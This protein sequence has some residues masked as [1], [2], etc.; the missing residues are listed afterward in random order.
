MSDQLNSNID[1]E[2]APAAS[3]ASM[4]R[5]AKTAAVASLEQRL[6]GEDMPAP[7]AETIARAVVDPADARKRLDRLTPIRVPGG[8]VYA[9]E[10]TVW[11]T[12][13]VP[14]VV[15][16]REAPDRH[17]PAGIKLGSTEAARY[18][19]LRPP[20]NA[21]DGSARLEI[22]AR[23]KKHLIWSLERSAKFLL[24]HNNWTE[25]IGAQGVMQ[26]VT[27]AVVDVLFDNGEPTVTMLGSVDGSS[28]V[29]SSH[30]VL[31]VTPHDVLYRYAQDERAHRQFISTLLATLE[32][33]ATSVPADDVTKLRALEIPARIFVRF[34]PD[35]VT[36]ITFSKAVESF[37][38]LVHVETPQA[39]DPAASLDAKADSVLNELVSEG[40]IT[41][42]RKAYFEGMLTPE[43]ARAAKMPQYLDERALEI[44]AAI[45]SEKAANYRAV[46]QGILLL[47][48]GGVVQRGPKAE[49]AVE[50]A[51]RGYRSNM[52]RAEQKGA[53]ETLQNVYLHSDIWAKGLRPTGETPEE[54]RDAALAELT[55]GGPKTA[56][57]RLAAQA[58][59]WLAVQR[60][61]REARFFDTDKNLRDP[62]TPQRVLND[63]MRTPRGVHVLYRA[64]VDGRDKVPI[65][66]VDEKGT[67]VKGVSGK[68]LEANHAWVRTT[69][70]PPV[71]PS[72]SK[73]LAD[74]TNGGPSL[75]D[76][77][78]LTRLGNLRQAVDHLEDAHAQLRD[79]KDAS[80]KVLVDQDGIAADTVDDLLTRLDALRT[81]L[82][83]YRKTWKEKNAVQ[84]ED[85]AADDDTGEPITDLDN[86]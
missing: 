70:A 16:N 32:K 2:P 7:M 8:I 31:G 9:L 56:C 55:A 24:D 29:N 3:L 49:I 12:T 46:R 62:R 52:T 23:E 18:K 81:D 63:L 61:L 77:V 48:K 35:P 22:A 21:A 86:A 71:V 60:L 36:P 30:A 4:Q 83:I 40:A 41:P 75:P 34:E 39:W 45:S 78:L 57:L 33:P 67:R 72:T 53:R 64:L 28:R 38:H 47:T 79:V 10:T 51:L 37:V 74:N 59:Y 27:L 85:E 43:E 17:F 15:N 5:L 76:R 26:H 6:V 42:K 19:P 54:L 80:G 50:L 20:T 84:P 11:A 68:L 69:A 65:V 25:S 82:A 1:L 73:A 66:Q 13:I 14:Y 58:A 44:I